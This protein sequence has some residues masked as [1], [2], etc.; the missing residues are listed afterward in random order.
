M[1]LRRIA[2]VGLLFAATPAFAIKADADLW[3]GY[4][5]PLNISAITDTCNA[6]PSTGD[7]C[8]LGGFSFG[9]SSMFGFGK[10]FAAGVG[11]NY[12]S[13]YSGSLKYSSTQSLSVKTTYLPMLLQARFQIR[14]F[15]VQ[16]GVGY[17]AALDTPKLTPSGSVN[18][19]GASL[20]TAMA[21]LGFSFNIAETVSF[22]VAG[23]GFAMYNPETT[24]IGYAVTPILGF[25]ALLS[26]K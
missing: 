25:R 12:L 19:N 6:Y 2:F 23:K 22:V 13:L 1:H 4:S 14:W 7:D 16:T 10:W 17:A 11:L 21:E 20:W 26:D 18:F 15:Y 3:G 9:A 8:R 5:I 24:S